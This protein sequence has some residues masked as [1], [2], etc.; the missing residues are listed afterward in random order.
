MKLSRNEN[1]NAIRWI[2]CRFKK[3]LPAVGVISLLA[4][5][6]S[7]SYIWLAL[8]S[9]RVLDIATKEIEGSLLVCGILLLGTVVAQIVIDAV[10]VLIKTYTSGKM[11]IS[12][13]NYLFGVVA[14]RKYSKISAY[15][16]GDLLNRFTSD[17]EVVISS[18]INIIPN[19]CA[20]LAKIVG[21]LW[22]LVILDAKIAVLVFVLGFSVPAFGRLINKKFKKMHKECQ[23]SE[24]RVRSFLQECFENTVII[25]TFGSIKLFTNK[26]NSFMSENL[27][28]KIK[29]SKISLMAHLS[30]YSFFS[31]G[32]YAVLLWGAGNIY[33]ATMT[34]GTLTAFLQLVSQLRAP[35]Q[36]ISGILP[37][38]YSAVASAERLIEIEAGDSDL[39]PVNS[40]EL[41]RIKNSFDYISVN[42]ITFAYKDELVLKNCC[43]TAERGKITA[44]TG[45]SGSGKSTVFKL[46]LGLYE[47]LSG[48]ICL[49]GELKLNTSHRGLF[50][51][52]PQGNLLLS[53]TIR[54]NITLCDD[55]IPEEE[56]IKACK[57]AEIYDI[58]EALPDGLN[59][60]LGER[61]IG[62]SEGQIQRISLA[63]A[64]LTDAPVLLLDEATSG[65]DEATETRVLSNIKKFSDKTIIFV[66]HRN[67]SLKICD[68]I[69]HVDGMKFNTIKE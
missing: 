54:E 5:L 19:I 35:L 38:Y 40:D 16:S 27:R 57:T 30:L 13:R 23:E 9:K 2:F 68:K 47:P 43:F 46:M 14:S 67:T 11:S 8:V 4:S 31:L 10:Q 66:T 1:F 53:G 56:I 36:N 59:S 33:N 63:R 34:Y 6:I 12:L 32:Y 29:R 22:A 26:L 42:N 51:Y 64:V 62:L 69:I 50:A 49:D 18:I 39:P 44:I 58:I 21:G 48:E 28:L 41:V 45:E 3:Y 25:K 24:G 52:V 55:T 7:L 20:T 15:H 61:G 37:Q 65:L 17:G 60:M